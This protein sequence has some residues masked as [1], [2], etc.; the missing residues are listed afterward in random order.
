MSGTIA[1]GSA[2]FTPLV[3]DL[4]TGDARVLPPPPGYDESYAAL[5]VSGRTIVGSACEPPASTSENPRC[6]AAAWTLP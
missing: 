5:A 2:D 6:V 3:W 4:E 1:V